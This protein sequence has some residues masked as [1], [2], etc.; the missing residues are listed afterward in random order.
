MVLELLAEDSLWPWSWPTEPKPMS[1]GEEHSECVK[2]WA[3][4]SVRPG[5]E[6]SLPHD[7]GHVA[8]FL[9]SSVRWGN[10]R[11]YFTE[12]LRELN[13]IKCLLLQDPTYPEPL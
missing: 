3:L 11:T 9:P 8:S 6:S 5:F 4:G 7:P 12:L 13:E 10:S 2:S 1:V